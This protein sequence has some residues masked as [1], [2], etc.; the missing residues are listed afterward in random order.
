MG[1]GSVHWMETARMRALCSDSMMKSVLDMFIVDFK[2]P[3][4]FAG[5]SSLM[6][7]Q[8]EARGQGSS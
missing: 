5:I 1:D 6:E 8:P 7:L 4:E 2:I 3:S